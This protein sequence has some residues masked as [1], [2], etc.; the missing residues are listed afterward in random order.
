MEI[1]IYIVTLCLL[2]IN[3]IKCNEISHFNQLSRLIQNTKIYFHLENRAEMTLDNMKNKVSDEELFKSFIKLYQKSYSFESQEGQK[4]FKQFKE[5]LIRIE[6]LNQSHQGTARFGITPFI[7]ELG[8]E[9]FFLNFDEVADLEHDDDDDVNKMRSDFNNSQ[10]FPQIKRD[11]QINFDEMADLEHDDDDDD[12]DKMRSDFNN[13]QEFPQIKRDRQINFDEMADLEHDDDDVD[14]MRSDFNNSQEFQQIKRDR[15]I[16]FDEMAD[17]EHDDDDDVDKMRSDFNN[18][19]EFPQIKRDRQINFDEVADEIDSHDKT[20]DKNTN[21]KADKNKYQDIIFQNFMNEDSDDDFNRDEK[22]LKKSLFLK[23]LKKKSSNANR[24]LKFLSFDD[25][26]D[27]E[28]DKVIPINEDEDEEMIDDQN[29]GILNYKKR[30]DFDSDKPEVD[31]KILIEKEQELGVMGFTKRPNKFLNEYDFEDDENEK[32]FMDYKNNFQP[33]DAL[34]PVDSE[35]KFKAKLAISRDAWNS[36]QSGIVTSDVSCKK[37]DF[38]NC[39]RTV[40][41]LVVG[42]G[43]DITTQNEFWIIKGSYGN[44]WGEEGYMKVKRDDKQNN[45][46]LSCN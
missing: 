39:R 18:S 25:Y 22:L 38:I 11:R 36:Y 7:D 10:E 2:I 34:K 33:S 31:R 12:V 35:F 17:L 14:K 30:P 19:Q 15:Q 21:K 16:N 4:R 3:I 5:A 9:F 45:Y 8:H 23:N 26:V 43:Y 28:D 41:V 1:Y 46:G 24:S 37:C 40:D 29:N 32:E 42:K 27:T 13:S 44:N 20:N 6:K